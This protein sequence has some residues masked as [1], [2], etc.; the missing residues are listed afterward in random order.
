[1]GKRIPPLDLMWLIME[2]QAS[3]THV[4]AL[5]LFEKPK[6]R[7]GVVQEIV[8]A[9]R[10][11]EPTPPFNYIPETGGTGLPR[12]QETKSWDPRYHIQ[13]ISLAPGAS[14]DDLLRL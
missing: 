7:P 9:Y 4:G 12:F 6:G 10:S 2:T 1:M 3:P 13:H 14:Y 8:D 11:C 5:L